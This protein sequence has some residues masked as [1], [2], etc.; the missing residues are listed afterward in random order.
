MRRRIEELVREILRMRICPEKNVDVDNHCGEAVTA[1]DRQP[2]DELETRIGQIVD[3][4]RRPIK[5][6]APSWRRP[7]SSSSLPARRAQTAPRP[8]LPTSGRP[9]S[10][11]R[12]ARAG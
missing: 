9:R 4:V 2:D 10:S 7:S 5:A 12:S 11:P 3:D 8:S 1:P 6:I